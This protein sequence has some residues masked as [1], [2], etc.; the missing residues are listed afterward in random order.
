MVPLRPVDS[1]ALDAAGYDTARR[2]LR[3]AFKGGRTYVYLDVPPE[4]Y[5]AFL[6]A[7]SKGRFV[8]AEIKPRHRCVEG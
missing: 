5:E 8:N 2:E 6:Q 4:T 3:V 7:E 1:S